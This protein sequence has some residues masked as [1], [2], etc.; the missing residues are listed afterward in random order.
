MKFV[1]KCGDDMAIENIYIEAYKGLPLKDIDHNSFSSDL[2]LRLTPESVKLID[3]YKYKQYVKTFRDNID[4]VLWYEIPFAFPYKIFETTDVGTVTWY[5]LQYDEK[6]NH[7]YYNGLC[8]VGAM[9]AHY[10]EWTL[11]I[12]ELEEYM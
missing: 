7:V 9:A 4:H 1:K 6:G 8:N 12:D 2:Y 10:A 11:T 5:F 3:R